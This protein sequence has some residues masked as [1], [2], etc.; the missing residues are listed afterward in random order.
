MSAWRRR[1]A[2][3]LVGPYVTLPERDGVWIVARMDDG[4]GLAIWEAD[5]FRLKS[6]TNLRALDY[7]REAT[8][9]R[10]FGRS[11]TFTRFVGTV[12]GRA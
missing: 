10:D 3:W 9:F 7:D 4:T 12:K 2:R 5:R 6:T 8:S 11:G 1:L